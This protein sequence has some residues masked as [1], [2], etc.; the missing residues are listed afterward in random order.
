MATSGPLPPHTD[1]VFTTQAMTLTYRPELQALLVT[2]PFTAVLPQDV[3]PTLLCHSGSLV[4]AAYTGDLDLHALAVRVLN[5]ARTMSTACRTPP[6]TSV[7]P[8]TL[9]AYSMPVALYV[10]PGA[11]PT[12]C[13]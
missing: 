2:T 5:T 13:V 7:G 10:L 6:V 8:H 1:L 12:P 4:F 9:H 3:K 11:P